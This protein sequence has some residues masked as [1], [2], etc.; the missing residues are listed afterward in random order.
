[1]SGRVGALHFRSSLLVLSSRS[2]LAWPR[3]VQESPFFFHL[4]LKGCAW[5]LFL[6]P[7]DSA[8]QCAPSDTGKMRR[9]LSQVST[10]NKRRFQDHLFSFFLFSFLSISYHPFHRSADRPLCPSPPFPYILCLS[11]PFFFIVTR[12]K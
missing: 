1:M 11:R 4:A 5:T 10:K 7:T 9:G 3:C 8:F 2:T 6:S 12:V